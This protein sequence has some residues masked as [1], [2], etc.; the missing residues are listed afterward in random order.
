MFVAATS[1]FLPTKSV[2]SFL[3]LQ[4]LV[5]FTSILLTPVLFDFNSFFESVDRLSYRESLNPNREAKGA[6][7]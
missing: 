5:A 6:Y 2:K 1:I 7:E 3:M 4:S